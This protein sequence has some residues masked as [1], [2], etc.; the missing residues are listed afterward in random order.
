MQKNIQALRIHETPNIYLLHNLGTR[1]D[2]TNIFIK[3]FKNVFAIDKTQD[4][5]DLA[6]MSMSFAL[7]DI[8]D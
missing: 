5:V 2:F 8:Q 1:V 6:D 3:K 4:Q 7:M